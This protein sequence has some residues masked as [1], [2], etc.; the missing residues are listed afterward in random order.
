MVEQEEEGGVF[1]PAAHS[2]DTGWYSGRWSHTGLLA[3]PL[4]ERLRIVTAGWPLPG[5]AG[6]TTPED[7]WGPYILGPSGRLSS[8]PASSV[9]DQAPRRTAPEVLTPWGIASPWAAISS[10][11]ISAISSRERT[12]AAWRS[13]IA[14]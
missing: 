5:W 14:A 6:T 7:K 8:H 4:E 2:V 12:L 10:S 13:S 3:H 1:G 11:T 9:A